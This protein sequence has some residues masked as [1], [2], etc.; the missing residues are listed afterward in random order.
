MKKVTLLSAL[1][2]GIVSAT[3]LWAADHIDAPAVTNTSSDITD[4]YAFASPENA[5][6]MVFVCNVQGLL[7][8]G[9]ATMDASFDENVMVEF[10][11]DNSGDN[12]EDLVIQCIFENGKMKVYG[13]SAPN[14]S[15]TRSKLLNNLSSVDVNVSAYNSSIETGSGNGMKVFAGPR[16]DPFFFDL[17]AY[18]DILS[19]TATMFNDPGTDTFAGTNVMSIVVEVPKS[20]LGN[21]ATLNTWV[22]S[23]TKM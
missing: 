23:K 9:S 12:V 15:G 4:Y 1:I 19:G 21:S 2:I 5:D 7:A 22:E 14:E 8:P 6:N 10:N 16:D 3:L 17:T 18:T 20:E 13:P 11:I